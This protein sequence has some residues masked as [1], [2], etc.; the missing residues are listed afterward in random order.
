[1][2][3]PNKLDILYAILRRNFAHFIEKCFETVSGGAEYLRNYHIDTIAHSLEHCRVFKEKRLIITLPPRSLK[4]ICASIAYPAFILGHDPT[5]RIICVSYSN[6]L[7]LKHTRDFRMVINSP[8]YREVFPGT[9]AAR[10]IDTEFETTR[11]GGRLAVPV[12]GSITG[13]GGNFIIIDD[14]LKAEDALSRSMRDKCNE[15]FKHTLYSRLDSKVDGVIVLVMQR[16]HD[17]DLAGHLLKQGGWPHLNLPAIATRDERIALNEGA[18]HERKVGDVLHPAREPREALDEIKN[19][20][21]TLHFQAQ[22]QQSPVP[23]AGNLVQRAWFRFFEL[24]PPRTNST[25]TVQSWDTAVKGDPTNDFSVCSTWLT[26]NGIHYLLDVTRH[27]CAYPALLQ[28]AVDQYRRHEPDAVLIEDQGSGSIL[29]QDLRHRHQISAIPIKPIG[30]KTTRLGAASIAI[31]NGTV[32]LPREA[33]WL[34]VFLNEL[35]AFPQTRFDDQVDSVSQY[36]IW[37]Q[38]RGRSTFEVFWT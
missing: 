12:G 23:E 11:G 29:I 10:D 4:S 17:D 21:G 32:Y 15:Y 14:P 9:L 36:L 8:W 18:Y 22:Y 26:Q 20:L 19:M 25:R 3:I 28:L 33:P 27:Q 38:G 5:R 6:E 35:L 13:R 1:M 31:E 16:L 34:G 7:A 2:I 30:D 24:P 37:D